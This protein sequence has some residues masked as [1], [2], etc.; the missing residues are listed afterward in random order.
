M[1]IQPEDIVSGRCYATANGQVRQVLG[2][3]GADVFYQARTLA[4][5]V[6]TWGPRK[7]VSAVN[8]AATVVGE[9]ACD[10]VPEP[11]ASEPVPEPVPEPE[12]AADRLA[13]ARAVLGRAAEAADPH[14]RLAHLY[15]AAEILV[16]AIEDQEQALRR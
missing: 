3:R 8:F 1:P 2:S 9:V 15:A 5:A 12:P 16:K 4:M 6:G 10:A 13:E 7:T 14:D 11:A